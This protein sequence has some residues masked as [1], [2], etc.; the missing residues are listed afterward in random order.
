MRAILTFHSIDPGDTILSFPQDALAQLL[1]GLS[2]AQIPILTLDALLQQATRRGVALTFDDG[3]QSVYTH[4]LPVLRDH[5]A[6][7]HLF[8]TTG[9]VGG[10]NCGRGH[11]GSSL[12][13]LDWRQVEALQAA[14]VRTESHTVNHR[15]LCT[16]TNTDIAAECDAADRV[17]MARLGH[18]PQYF[19]YPYGANDERVRAIMRS[20]YT[21]A[22]TT[23][24]RPLR[25]YEDA[26]ALPRLDSY[27][28]RAKWF[29]RNL[30]SH[31]ARAYLTLRRVLR[32]LRH[33]R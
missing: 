1:A 7:A 6:P 31:P 20:R 27:Y 26:A 24:L 5:G 29:H 4:A 14:G 23:V 11:G 25:R 16:L 3:F 22:L 17:I 32:P 19:A 2:L 15:D 10:D 18:H 12:P 33:L 30:D 8:L 9:F 13:M 21:A 28:L